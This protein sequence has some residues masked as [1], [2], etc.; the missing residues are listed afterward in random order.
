MLKLINLEKEKFDDFVFNK[1]Y[2]IKHTH[3][4]IGGI[5]AFVVRYAGLSK[6]VQYRQI[7]RR[8]FKLILI[9]NKAS[10]RKTV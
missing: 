3:R 1:V 6:S 9:K 8:N 7:L 2:G 10:D 4:A 5:F